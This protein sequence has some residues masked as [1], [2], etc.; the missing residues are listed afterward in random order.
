MAPVLS[1]YSSDLNFKLKGPGLAVS[2]NLIVNACLGK[3]KVDWTI[4]PVPEQIER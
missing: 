4:L 3:D 1:Y 2:L